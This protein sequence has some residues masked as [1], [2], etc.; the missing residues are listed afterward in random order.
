M[1]RALIVTCVAVCAFS[2][3]AVQADYY[4]YSVGDDQLKYNNDT[5]WAA[6]EP[7]PE[8]DADHAVLRD[9]WDAWD[10]DRDDGRDTMYDD[11]LW[12]ANN[13]ESGD[14][15]MYS[16][17]GHGGWDWPDSLTPVRDEGN[18]S[19]PDANDPTPANDPPYEGEEFFGYS[20]SYYM[21]DDDFRDVFANFHSDIQVIVITAA[22]HSGGWVGG[23]YDLDTSAPATNKGLYAILG[24]P[25]HGYGIM[26]GVGY[27]MEALLTTVLSNTIEPFMTM[28]EWYAAAMEYGETGYYELQRDW[29]E[30]LKT[31][32]YWP[33]EDWVP[34]THEDTWY[35]DHWGWE[36]AYLQLRPE[37]YS[38]LDTEHD[39]PV[40]TPEPATMVLF[41]L[42]LV[43]FAARLRRRKES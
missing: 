12:Y 8:W 42:G 29:D 36:E 13:L 3:L 6:L 5:L 22:C 7:Y 23:D 9:N 16:Y 35:T 30:D 2:A 40:C 41:G 10:P 28:S 38:T 17:F 11:L 18:T 14:V 31:Y 4:F 15:F 19:R 43:G 20:G 32:C 21:F 26:V 27:Y 25:E 33:D 37:S 1:K 34:T 39:N 24:A